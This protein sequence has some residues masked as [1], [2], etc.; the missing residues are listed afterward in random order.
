MIQMLTWRRI[1]RGRVGLP[2]TPF[3]MVVSVAVGMAETGQMEMRTSIVIRRRGL[4]DCPM[5]MRYHRQ[6]SGEESHHQ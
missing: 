1:R 3:V 6:L 4:A 2:L 5:R